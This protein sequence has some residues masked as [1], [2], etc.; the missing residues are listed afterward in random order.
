MVTKE[1]AMDTSIVEFHWG[2]CTR[3]VG[4]RGG[5]TERIDKWR[6]NGKCKLWITR[7]NEFKLPIK[8]GMKMC[9][10]ITNGCAGDFH[11]A[12]DCPLR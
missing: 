5:I 2:Y 11:T 8:Y 1:Q 4:P 12:E 9:G 7:P 10:Y 6:R 3:T